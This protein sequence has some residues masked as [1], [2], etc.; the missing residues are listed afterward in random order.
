MAP[1]QEQVLQDMS[2]TIEGCPNLYSVSTNKHNVKVIKKLISKA[3][4]IIEEVVEEPTKKETDELVAIGNAI[5]EVYN[6]SKDVSEE[7]THFSIWVVSYLYGKH[8][9]QTEYID[10]EVYDEWLEEEQG[11][12]DECVKYYID[13]SKDELEQKLVKCEIIIQN[14][15]E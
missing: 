11:S 9:Y 7:E 2:Q 1:N 12:F 10:Q 13:E 3:R 14:N 4:N 8:F 15:A 6:K 5:K